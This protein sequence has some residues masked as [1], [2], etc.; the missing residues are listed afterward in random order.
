MFNIHSMLFKALRGRAGRGGGWQK[1]VVP[2]AIIPG[3]TNHLYS[4]RLADA[5]RRHTTMPRRIDGTTMD[6]GLVSLLMTTNVFVRVC[7]ANGNN[8][9]SEEA[10]MLMQST[11][12]K[13]N[14]QS[15]RMDDNVR[16]I[17]DVM[18]IH[19]NRAT[20]SLSCSMFSRVD[21]YTAVCMPAY[22]QTTR[23]YIYIATTT[24]VCCVLSY[25]LETSNAHHKVNRKRTLCKQNART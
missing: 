18:R 4:E 5:E 22:K 25:S 10:L 20:T 12:I 24:L 2:L 14:K 17:M 16:S 6:G 19:T 11:N 9:P 13:N 15:Q 23:N 8:A 7:D 3:Y 1:R 21:V